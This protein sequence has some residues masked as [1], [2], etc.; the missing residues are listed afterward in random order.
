MHSQIK[1]NRKLNLKPHGWQFAFY[2]S[3]STNKSWYLQYC[4]ASKK[5][6]NK[7]HKPFDLTF[8]YKLEYMKK[9]SI[10]VHCK[11]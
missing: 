7:R 10:S 11:L 4:T 8:A 1:R 6:T 2:H 9:G 3:D 5:K